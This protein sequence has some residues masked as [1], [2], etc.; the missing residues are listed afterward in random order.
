VPPAAGGG[1]QPAAVRLGDQLALP[2]VHLGHHQI[3]VRQHAS[4]VGR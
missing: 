2:V 3:W 4:I 1:E